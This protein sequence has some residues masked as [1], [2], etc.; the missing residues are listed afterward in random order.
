MAYYYEV[1]AMD[2]SD[3]EVVITDPKV[4][5]WRLKVRS[6]DL[7]TLYLL[8]P[9][10]IRQHYININEDD[11]TIT[12]AELVASNVHGDMTKTT[13]YVR[14]YSDIQE[15][16]VIEYR[17]LRGWGFVEY[18]NELKIARQAY[19][20]WRGGEQTYRLIDNRTGEVLLTDEI[21]GQE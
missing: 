2:L 9:N 16:Y 11:K 17:A 15:N 19:R 1:G 10:G 13:R 20:D 4:R 12:P 5:S 14:T 6:N 8:Y 3:L 7:V 21:G 18:M